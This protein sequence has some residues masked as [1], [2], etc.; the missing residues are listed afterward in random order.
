MSKK[1]LIISTSIRP[2][3]NSELLANAFADGAR[4]SGNEVELVSLKDKTIGFCKGCLACQK[5]GR[6]VVKDDANEITE[7]LLNAEV[8]V[9][10]TPIYYYEM[11]GQMKTMIDRA[12][13]LYPRDYQFRD[14]YLL[15]TAA[16]DEEYVDEGACKGLQ[17]W[18]DC[19]EKTQFAGKIFAGGYDTPK[20]IEGSD[21]L[22]KAYEMGKAAVITSG[23]LKGFV[24]ISPQWA[25]M[26]IDSLTEICK[27]AYSDDELEKI[28]HESK[29]QSGEEHSKVLSM[30]FN[31]YQVPNGV[32]FLNNS[33]PALTI[34]PRSIKFN[35]AAHR[36]INSEYVEFLFHP[37]LKTV[38]LRSCDESALNAF[39]LNSSTSKTTEI[40]A[41]AFCQAIY[42][43]MDWIKKYRFRFRGIARCREGAGIMMF[44]LDEPQILADKA[45]REKYESEGKQPAVCYI[46]YRNCELSDENPNCNQTAG[47]GIT[48]A[49]RKR[50]D[51]LMND[52]RKSDIETSS[53]AVINPKIG[54]IPTKEEVREEL[55]NL[56]LSM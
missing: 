28:E 15:M 27:S 38:A 21:K 2:N 25:G 22:K 32:F 24:S 23:A 8:V 7:K 49:M 6:C 43:K 37:I 45:T 1:V 18:I 53:I 52:I 19:F 34:S 17:G 16:E 14:V 56:L 48:M 40:S 35:K 41:T 12:N 33:M 13:S 36:K 55:D 30:E 5:L 20:S 44:Y 11:S 9:W 42:D 46:P 4:K 26:D 31:G 54:I 47:F 39:P 50:R 3:S 29:I 51:A 10:A